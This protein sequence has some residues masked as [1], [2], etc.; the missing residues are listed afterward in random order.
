MKDKNLKSYIICVSISLIV[1][2]FFGYTINVPGSIRTSLKERRFS[3]ETKPIGRQIRLY[4]INNPKDCRIQYNLTKWFNAGYAIFPNSNDFQKFYFGIKNLRKDSIN[5]KN[6]Q[7]LIFFYDYK[8]IEVDIGKSVPWEPSYPPGTYFI[9][10]RDELQ[11]SRAS[12]NSLNALVIK[13]KNNSTSRVKYEIKSD[14]HDSEIGEFY[15]Y[16][17]EMLAPYKMTSNLYDDPIKPEMQA[18]PCIVKCR[19]WNEDEK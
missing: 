4:Q 7:L 15:V 13:F 19:K 10:I 12:I 16:V 3:I 9:N 5:I 18:T 6:P 2:F 8:N 17:G 14:S 1:L 11:P